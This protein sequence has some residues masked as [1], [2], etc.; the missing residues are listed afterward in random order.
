MSG[1]RAI[2]GH[3]QLEG[4]NIAYCLH[5]YAV[6]VTREITQ[7]DHMCSILARDRAIQPG[8]VIW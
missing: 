4:G 7:S 6:V 2:W 8:H 3:I 5:C 1:G